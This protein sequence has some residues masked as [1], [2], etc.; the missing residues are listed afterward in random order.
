MLIYPMN[1]PIRTMV[2]SR[3]EVTVCLFTK[4][5]IIRAYR[6]GIEKEKDMIMTKVKW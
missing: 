3:I 2:N 1:N 4:D 6:D 5:N